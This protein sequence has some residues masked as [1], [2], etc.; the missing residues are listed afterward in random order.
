MGSDASADQA[1]QRRWARRWALVAFVTSTTAATV[2]GA[3][4][5]AACSSSPSPAPSPE[6]GGTPPSPTLGGG[7]DPFPEDASVGAQARYVLGG[8]TG[9]PESGCHGLGAGGMVLPDRMPSNLI[10]TPS[11]EEPAL[12]RIK[13]G[14]PANSYL[15]RKIM[16]G[17]AIDGGRMPLDQSP[18]DERSTS[19]IASWIE[20][21]APAP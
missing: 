8:C 6:E 9:G 13:R 20:A 7:G 15:Y 17:P 1:R 11:S 3:G 10:D 12:F 19:A 14:D 16:G 5:S 4:A 2:A 18:L 21:G